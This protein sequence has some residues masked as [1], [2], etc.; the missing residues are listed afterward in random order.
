MYRRLVRIAAA[1]GLAL[2]FG[3]PPAQ[4]GYQD[5][6]AAYERGDYMR[7]FA[8]LEAAAQAGNT[9]AQYYLGLMY[10]NGQG[11]AKDENLAGQW[12]SCA[13]TGSGENRSEAERLRNQLSGHSGL[14]PDD[15]QCGLAQASDRQLS[16]QARE[17]LYDLV[18]DGWMEMVVYMPADLMAYLMISA[19]E[20][21]NQ[22]WLVDAVLGIVSSTG[23]WFRLGFG[24]VV[25][26]MVSTVFLRFSRA[27][28]RRLP[29][30]SGALHQMGSAEKLWPQ[31]RAKKA[32]TRA[33]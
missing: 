11:V 19:A 32:K 30:G 7:A 14:L 22:P 4:A 33:A 26:F 9:D 29:S 20:T 23:N 28:D 17:V 10:A 15:L 24:L 1:I 5:G 2:M 13:A 12:L 21:F 31:Q 16:E 25:W 3:A 27:L 18:C 6:V 8:E